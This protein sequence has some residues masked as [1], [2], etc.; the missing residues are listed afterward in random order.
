MYIN[1]RNIKEV[2]PSA[3]HD[4]FIVLAEALKTGMTYE[5]P[6]LVRNPDELDI[7]FGRGSSENSYLKSL[8][9]NNRSLLLFGSVK[10]RPKLV[11]EDS[12]RNT[13]EN[14]KP[15][16]TYKISTSEGKY[17]DDFG[18]IYDKYTLI[19]GELVD[20]DFLPPQET[21][22]LLNRDS[23][24]ISPGRSYT[25]VYLDNEIRDGS[26][27]YSISGLDTK[28]GPGDYIILDKKLIYYGPDLYDSTTD[29]VLLRG[30]DGQFIPKG[31]YTEHQNLES[32]KTVR[33]LLGGWT[34]ISGKL[35]SQN[36]PGRP[37]AITN[38]PGLFIELSKSDTE[39][40]KAR[41]DIVS[42]KFWSKT[43]GR[44]G[45]GQD[46]ITVSIEKTLADDIWTVKISR[47]EYQEFYTGK[48]VSEPGTERLDYQINRES[49]LVYCQLGPGEIPVGSWTLEGA[50]AEQSGNIEEGIKILLES[51]VDMIK[52]DFLLVPYS[53]INQE[54]LLGLCREGNFQAL[55]QNTDQDYHNNLSD[56]ENY[57]IYFYRTI[58]LKD[59]GLTVPGYYL[60]LKGLLEG[61]LEFRLS[62]I[63][64][65]SPLEYTKVNPF[66][67]KITDLT[68]YKSNYLVNSGQYY[69]YEQI[70]SGDAPKTSVWMRFVL[71]KIK[72]ELEKCKFR[73]IGSRNSGKI[74]EEIFN[75][76]KKIDRN[77]S[78][79]RSIDLSD[80]VFDLGTGIAYLRIT[81]TVSSLVDRTVN[82]D[83]TIN[84]N[85]N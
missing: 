42:L 71:E 52:P 37:A 10:E 57:L 41:K 2:Y 55:V 45:T 72:R 15:G 48:F 28:V 19:D 22:S 24:Q 5:R 18:V 9:G 3:E 30:L 63:L 13:V 31:L 44:D 34:I 70:I 59:S 83:L 1:L 6:V 56:P 61:N 60:F 21:P 58:R 68:R 16:V 54:W 80:F 33:D 36:E 78:F 40:L 74:R 73:V 26:S 81:T 47:Y 14:P 64:Y 46:S 38:I 76:L 12:V 39:Q 66:S 23:L 84:F 77:F 65:D 69:F 53:G 25:G 43:I 67:N 20:I 4:D 11:E 75:S 62:N 32:A 27:V 82:L 29:R 79:V 35:V 8:L 50:V 51:T 7:W 17:V 49:K 85:K